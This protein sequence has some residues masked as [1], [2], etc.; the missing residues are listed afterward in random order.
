MGNLCTPPDNPG[1]V[2]AQRQLTAL[3]WVIPALTGAVLAVN[4]RM[5]EQQRPTQATQGLCCGG[6]SQVASRPPRARRRGLWL[7]FNPWATGPGIRPSGWLNLLRDAAH[8]RASATGGA[9]HRAGPATC[10]AGPR[11]RRRCS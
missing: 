9:E 11:R 7:R 6:C 1:V 3:Q 8:G 4:A 5:G 10:P 2:R